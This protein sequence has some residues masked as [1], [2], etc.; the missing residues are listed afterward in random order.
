MNPDGSDPINLTNNKA[1]DD[2]PTL[3]TDGQK[4]AF[5]SNRDGNY[6]IYVVN[7]DGSTPPTNLTNNPANDMVP[8]WY[9]MIALKNSEKQVIT[10]KAAATP[11]LRP[12]ATALPTNT[13][14]PTA[15]P[16]PFIEACIKDIVTLPTIG[17]S[18]IK[19]L[20][21]CSDASDDELTKANLEATDPS[22]IW[23]ALIYDNQVMGTG[24]VE[25]QGYRT[26][27]GTYFSYSYPSQWKDIYSLRDVHT[28]KIVASKT[29][30]STPPKC[31]FSS[32]TLNIS[33]NHATCTGG[34]GQS[35]WNDAVII[36]WLKGIVK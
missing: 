25:C 7:T 20:V 9:P 36:R 2:T 21:N 31:V 1:D 10:I 11:T 28:G 19:K 13:P 34:E 8:N 15:T 4:I 17:T 26:D 14:S 23:Y 16:D 18:T 30:L 32:C 35:T 6:E 27:K 12:T 24:F 33:S 22:Q 3:S 29:F 5:E